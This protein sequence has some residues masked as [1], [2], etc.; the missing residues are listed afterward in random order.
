LKGE[1]ILKAPSLILAWS[2]KIQ[3]MQL[4]NNSMNVY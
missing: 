3:P 4:R 1:N 2:S